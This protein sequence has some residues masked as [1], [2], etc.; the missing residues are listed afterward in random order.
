MM[1]HKHTGQAGSTISFL[2]VGGALLILLAGGLYVLRNRG[3]EGEVK[4]SP[5]VHQKSP[6]TSVAVKPKPTSTPESSKAP[7]KHPSKIPS[8]PKQDNPSSTP[9]PATGPSEDL[10][11][12]GAFGLLVGASVAYMQSRKARLYLLHR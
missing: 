3:E 7:A 6:S 8:A 11:I 9:L 4:P 12:A 1:N 10:S 5:S 2:L